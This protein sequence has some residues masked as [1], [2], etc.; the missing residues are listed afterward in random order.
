MNRNGKEKSKLETV[1]V[2][3]FIDNC[4]SCG[5]EEYG[6][7]HNGG[8]RCGSHGGDIGVIN[9]VGD[10]AYTLERGAN[11]NA[12]NPLLVSA[13]PTADI[14]F[15]YAP[16]LSM[17]QATELLKSLGAWN[18]DMK[19]FATNRGGKS[20]IEYGSSSNGGLDV[21]KD[22]DGNVTLGNQSVGYITK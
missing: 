21:L 10:I 12:K 17:K 14:M 5:I 22:K 3:K 8:S 19:N 9:L 20:H 15:M 13:I 2:K 6:F 7:R 4:N 11:P 1:D 18:D 16:D